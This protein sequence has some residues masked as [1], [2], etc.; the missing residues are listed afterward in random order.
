MELCV[1]EVVSFFVSL[2]LCQHICFGNSALKRAIETDLSLQ[3]AFTLSPILSLP[4]QHLV[5]LQLAIILALTVV[6]KTGVQFGLPIRKESS[7]VDVFFYVLYILPS[8]GR[9]CVVSEHEGGRE[10]PDLRSHSSRPAV[11][12]SSCFLDEFER[13]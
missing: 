7:K 4:S 1:V 3:A 9:P 6:L 12:E 8:G 10:L 2:M 11:Q 5:S 13:H